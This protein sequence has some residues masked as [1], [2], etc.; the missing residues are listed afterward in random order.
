MALSGFQSIGSTALSHI[1]RVNVHSYQGGNGR[2]DTLYDVASQ[3]GKALWNSEYGDG[4]ASG[5]DMV[6]NLL[7]DFRWLRPTGWVCWQ[8]CDMMTENRR[9]RHMILVLLRGC[10]RCPGTS[11][12]EE[13]TSIP[14]DLRKSVR[15]R[16]CVHMRKEPP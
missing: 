13:S 2:R 4:T 16:Q 3:A 6:S 8:V 11:S 7:Q 14:R 10:D 15:C 5:W 12:A 9:I 1:S